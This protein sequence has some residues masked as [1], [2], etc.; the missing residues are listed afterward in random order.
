MVHVYSGILGSNG[1][2]QTRAACINMDKS[3]KYNVS[4]KSDLQKNIH[5]Y[6]CIKTKA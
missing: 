6:V 3:H 2:E 5:D 1:D 4:K